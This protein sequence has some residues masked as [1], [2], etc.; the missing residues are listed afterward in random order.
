[1]I[2]RRWNTLKQKRPDDTPVQRIHLIG[3]LFKAFDTGNRREISRIN[4]Q[5]QWLAQHIN[6]PDGHPSMA[7]TTELLDTLRILHEHHLEACG[8]NLNDEEGSF[9]CSVSFGRK[10]TLAF[11][12]GRLAP[13]A[14]VGIGAVLNADGELITD[15]DGMARVLRDHW[16]EVFRAKPTE[17]QVLMEWLEGGNRRLWFPQIPEFEVQIEREHVLQAIK[18]AKNTAPGP[19]GVPYAAYK[20]SDVAARILHNATTALTDDTVMTPDDL[21]EAFLAC[22]PKKPERREGDLDVFKAKGTRPLSIGNTDNRLVSSALRITVFDRLAA[23]I[24]AMQRGFITGR[25][26]LQNVLEVDLAMQLMALKH[27][28]ALV[29]FFDFEAAFPSIAHEFIWEI[30]RKSGCREPLSWLCRDCT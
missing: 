15:T 29:I 6:D 3:L 25:S 17:P 26:M 5:H 10:K 21:N 23:W 12:L 11:K 14:T 1:M 28:R 27:V 8:R 2:W 9:P 30:L 20:D 13:G 18:S 19:D 24:S 16:G 22:L 7:N 4:H